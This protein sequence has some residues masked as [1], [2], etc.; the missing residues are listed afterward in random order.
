MPSPRRSSEQIRAAIAQAA[1]DVVGAGG[2]GALTHRAVA[3]E[4]E[5]SL[6]ST[7]YHFASRHDIIAA[8]IERLAVQERERVAVIAD[9]F[10]E[11]DAAGLRDAMVAAI[12]D[13]LAPE[14]RSR[15]RAQYELQLYAAGDPEL[16]ALVRVWVERIVDLNTE[17][18]RVLGAP[19]PAVASRLLVAAI[20]GLR[21]TALTTGEHAGGQRDV[22]ARLLAAL[23]S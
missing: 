6:S 17:A 11:L 10:E 13:E 3:A 5:V 2:L 7:T 18:L 21:L 16:G 14:D 4:A 8:A 1:I 20:D 19:D 9:A 12:C 15:L 23:T 22:A